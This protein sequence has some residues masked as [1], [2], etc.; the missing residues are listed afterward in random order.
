L[1]SRLTAGVGVPRLFAEIGAADMI[2]DVVSLG[3]EFRADAVLFDT[4]A[5]CGPLASELLGRI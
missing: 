4:E 5:F 3:R 1:I 2:D